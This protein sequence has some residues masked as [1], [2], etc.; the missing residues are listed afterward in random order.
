MNT[1]DLF[2]TVTELTG[3]TVPAPAT[4]QSFA[5]LLSDANAPSRSHNYTQIEANNAPGWATRNDRYKLI[6]FN[7][8]AEELYDL[9][10]DP[11]EANNLRNDASLASVR[12]ELFAYG[13]MIRGQ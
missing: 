7:S 6:V 4:S 11:D 12:D 9:N 5:A 8:G 3:I 1:T 2:A 10:N 13:Q